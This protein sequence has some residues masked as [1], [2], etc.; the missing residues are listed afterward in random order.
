MPELGTTLDSLE[1]G[2]EVGSTDRAAAVL[3]GHQSGL[4]PDGAHFGA[5][6]AFGPLCDIHQ[7][8][9]ALD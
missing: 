3:G 1:G 7:R 2:D 8:Q 5:A 4:G 9:F 6:P